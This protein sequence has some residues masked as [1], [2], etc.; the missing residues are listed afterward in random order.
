MQSFFQTKKSGFTLIETM[1]SVSI[2]VVVI[3]IGIGSL[4][5]IVSANK[6]LQIQRQTIDSMSFALEL[7]SRKIRTASQGVGGNFITTTGNS[8]S[9]TD[10]SGIPI[11]YTLQGN[12]LVSIDT[13]GNVTPLTPSNVEIADLRFT[14]AGLMPI[15]DGKAFIR[16]NLTGTIN[17]KTTSTPFSLQTSISPRLI[18]N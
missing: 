17:Y 8:L 12:E 10:Q 2:F 4:M 14:T 1:I 6:K 11:T 16:I 9:F 3:T 5:T 7:M 15:G 18:D 13:L